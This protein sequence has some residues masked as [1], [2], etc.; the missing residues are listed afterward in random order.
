M[1]WIVQ[2]MKNFGDRDAIIGKFDRKPEA[3]KAAA[4]LRET[5]GLRVVELFPSGLM[6]APAY[7]QQYWYKCPR[8]GSCKTCN[9]RLPAH[10]AEM[11][12]GWHRSCRPLESSL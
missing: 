1:P 9:C 8:G 2:G 11:R 7:Y 3:V 4:T 5:P 10:V 6:A 12:N